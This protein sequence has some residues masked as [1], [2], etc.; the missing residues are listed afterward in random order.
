LNLNK[1][2]SASEKENVKL[3]EKEVNQSNAF[4]LSASAKK[5]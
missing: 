4:A 1:G 3:E 2:L 5:V